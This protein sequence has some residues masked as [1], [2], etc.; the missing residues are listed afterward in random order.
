MYVIKITAAVILIAIWV[1]I[2]LGAFLDIENECACAFTISSVFT[3]GLLGVAYLL[4]A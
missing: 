3:V 1:V 2:N 4:L